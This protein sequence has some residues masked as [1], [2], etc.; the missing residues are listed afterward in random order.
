MTAAVLGQRLLLGGVEASAGPTRFTVS[1]FGCRR[2]WSTAFALVVAEARGVA[3][4]GQRAV[5]LGSDGTAAEV[6]AGP[7]GGFLV[8][9][10]P[11][12]HPA[13]ADQVRR[14][15]AEHG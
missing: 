10:G 2:A 11:E 6:R 3:V 9:P 5:I 7:G 4:A 13:W 12:P 14:L 15:L 1:V 8:D